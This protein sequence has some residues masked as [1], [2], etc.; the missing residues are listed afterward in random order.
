MF[1]RRGLSMRCAIAF[2]TL[3]SR[4]FSVNP[5]LTILKK[6][7]A[8][9]LQFRRFK[10][11][12]PPLDTD[13]EVNM[14]LSKALNR[15]V[16]N[17]ISCTIVD[18]K[19]RITASHQ[20]FR[21]T[22]LVSK[23]NL[24]PRDLRKIEASSHNLVPAILVRDTAI[25]I[26]LLF[27]RAILTKDCVLV[28]D[29]PHSDSEMTKL[30]SL[31]I[32]DL[33]HKL[34][35]PQATTNLTYE[36]RALEAIL[37]SVISALESE[38]KLQE[39]LVNA[40]LKELEKSLD[41]QRLQHLLV[42]SKSLAAFLQKVTLIKNELEEL[43]DNDEDLQG[44]TFDR[45]RYN[46]H[47]YDHRHYKNNSID[48]GNVEVMLE[49]YYTQCDEIVQ[50]ATNLETTIRS[51]EEYINILLDSNRNSLMLLEVRF[52]IGMLGLSCGSALAALYGMNLKN[53][54]EESNFGF[55]AVCLGVF[56]FS[57]TAITLC[58]RRLRKMTKSKRI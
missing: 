24:L 7:N 36:Q 22:D 19:G 6:S 38:F 3:Q 30:Q 17:S 12:Q 35:Q 14:I 31:F 20:R 57:I 50:G 58:L 23:F 5:A 37:V 43:I 27:V 33:Q 55:P 18:D 52:Q 56:T 25:V 42:Q 46:H 32:Y 47:H 26:N 10:T 54:I 8:F 53:Y 21:K 44:L 41:K 15:T 40:V 16:S 39:Q 2:R 9:P 11:T 45:Q 29:A 34:R 1:A 28:T 51:T 49:S 4:S 13:F 48:S